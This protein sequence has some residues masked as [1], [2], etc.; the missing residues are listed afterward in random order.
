LKN[1]IA[2]VGVGNYGLAAQASSKPGADC[3]TDKNHQGKLT[4]RSD[5]P[6]PATPSSPAAVRRRHDRVGAHQER[7]Q[8]MV[9][10][11]ARWVPG[12]KFA[13]RDDFGDAGLYAIAAADWQ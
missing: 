11:Y 1:K 4:A 9:A 6:V 7:V 8:I 2:V 13:A 3:G 10:D 12:R 5:S